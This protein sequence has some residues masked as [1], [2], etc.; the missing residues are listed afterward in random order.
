MSFL[1]LTLMPNLFT[2]FGALEGIRQGCSLSPY[3]FTLVVNELSL[4]L[5]EAFN[6]NRLQ[7][8]LPPHTFHDVL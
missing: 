7:G 6:S 5:Q 4:C 2:A 1:P 3:L 8:I